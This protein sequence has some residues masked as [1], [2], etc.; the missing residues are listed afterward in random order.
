MRP[1]H[2]RDHTTNFTPPIGWDQ[3]RDGHCGELSVRREVA[4]AGRDL[5][6]HYSTWT[7]TPAE[8]DRI[9]AGEVIE[10]CCVGIQP[11]VRI[12]V[13]PAPEEDSDVQG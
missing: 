4:G 13:V 12:D 1:T 3:E 5:I 11:P 9:A 6:Y 8:R 2:T 10:L 7:P